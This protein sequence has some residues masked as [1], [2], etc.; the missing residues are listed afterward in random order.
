MPV[1]VAA[2]GAAVPDE[3]L[4]NADLERMVDTSD[5]WIVQR[6]GIRKRHIAPEGTAASHLTSRAARTALEKAGLD[7]LELDLII[8]ATVTPDMPFPSTSCLVQEMIG[9][10]NAACFDLSA[11]CAGFLYGLSVAS[12]MIASNGFR[13][14]MVVGVEVLSRITDWADRGTC[15]LF[16]DGAGAAILRPVPVGRGILSTHLGSDGGAADFLK[17]PGGGSLHPASEKS[18]SA[19]LHTIKMQGR[20]VFNL[21]VKNMSRAIECVLDQAGCTLDD[22][23]CLIPHQANVR[24]IKSLCSRLG[25]P[26]DK[27]VVNIAEYGNTSSASI[28]IALAEAVEDGRLK[29]GD[30]AVLVSFGAGL[31]WAGIALRWGDA[32]RRERQAGSKN[33][34]H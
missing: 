6:T 9:A 20:Q 8:V 3:F 33:D 30:L 16:G 22:V 34:R 14:A 29:E 32:D 13:N 21:A 23:D 18:L 28:P 2:V 25:F 27:T 19:N 24:I 4:T 1:G 12:S 26:L 17:L 5:Q 15:V 11:G 10:G 7:P 31:T